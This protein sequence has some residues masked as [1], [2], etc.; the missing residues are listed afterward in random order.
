[1]FV[2]R[3]HC[4]WY[5][6]DTRGLHFNSADRQHY[7]PQL[8]WKTRKTL[9]KPPDPLPFP[10]PASAVSLNHPYLSL[11]SP[12]L[13][14]HFRNSLSFGQHGGMIVASTGGGE[15]NAIITPRAI[16]NIVSN[17]GGERRAV[18]CCRVLRERIGGLCLFSGSPHSLAKLFCR[19]SRC[20]PRLTKNSTKGN[21]ILL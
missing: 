6:S 7:I 8:L 4:L 2:L 15:L 13:L 17:D 11:P 5:N 3:P 12:P 9:I 1:M 19:C 10:P 14:F 20:Q 21:S 18:D 16:I